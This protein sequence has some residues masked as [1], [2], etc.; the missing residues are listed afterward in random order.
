MENDKKLFICFILFIVLC[1]IAVPSFL[2]IFFGNE[3]PYLRCFGVDTNG[4]LYILH[5]TDISV[6][7]NGSLVYT[8]NLHTSLN[9]IQNKVKLKAPSF[10]ITSD[11]HIIVAAGEYVCMLDLQGNLLDYGKDANNTQ[12]KLSMI[13]QVTTPNG[14][15]YCRENTLGRT[16]IVKN[17]SEVVYQITVSSLL[18]K[19]GLYLSAI[20][21]ICIVITII[22]WGIAHQREA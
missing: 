9:D 5:E 15:R 21:L 14:D 1:I 20:M 8:I 3:D 13:E 2:G 7:E 10:K 18:V 6:Y 12:V 19:L 16:A 11:D 22:R 17:S 4:R